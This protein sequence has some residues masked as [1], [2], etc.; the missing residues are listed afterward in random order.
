MALKSNYLNTDLISHKSDL[1]TQTTAMI[2]FVSYSS[3]HFHLYYK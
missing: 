2:I 1:H 3:H